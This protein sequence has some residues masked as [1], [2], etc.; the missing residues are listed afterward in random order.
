M[1]KNFIEMTI[2]NLFNGNENSGVF[3]TEEGNGWIL[4]NEDKFSIE[5][6]DNKGED[7]IEFKMLFD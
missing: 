5:Y 6:Q 3:I 4:K 2:V 1:A 7:L